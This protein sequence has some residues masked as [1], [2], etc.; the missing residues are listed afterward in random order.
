MAVIINEFEV[1]PETSDTPEETMAETSSA[2]EGG[3]QLNPMDMYDVLQYQMNRLLR[4]W[5]H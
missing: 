4:I 1:I 5:A 3:V 2:P